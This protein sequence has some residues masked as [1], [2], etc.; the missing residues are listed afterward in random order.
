SVT[1]LTANGS[2]TAPSDFAATNGT[3]TF[4]PGEVSKTINVSVAGDTMHEPDE[5]FTI[6]LSNPVGAKIADG[7]ATGTNS[8]DD[9][10]AKPGHYHGPISSGGV[11][12][13]DVSADSAS[14]SGVVM[15]AFMNCNPASES[16]V[17][18]FHNGSTSSIQP[19]LSFDAGGSGTGVSV[20]FL[21][22]FG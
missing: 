14:V 1:Y 9:L 4:A 21:G 15:A 6:S 12:D 19:D 17:Y 10:A 11:V 18:V 22:K 5:N 2:A 20:S 8:D 13:F 16:G 3:L 7:T